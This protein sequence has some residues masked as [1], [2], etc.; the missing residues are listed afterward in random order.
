M[1]KSRSF[2]CE[3]VLPI[4]AIC[5]KNGDDTVLVCIK[6]IILVNFPNPVPDDYM[7]LDLGPKSLLLYGSLIEKAESVFMN[8]ALGLFE[9]PCF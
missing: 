9:R 4:D 6:D 7:I 1:E 8:G 3:I 2:S 5:A